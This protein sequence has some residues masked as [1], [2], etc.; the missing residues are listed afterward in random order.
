MKINTQGEILTSLEL[1]SRLPLTSAGPGFHTEKGGF[2]A[3]GSWTREPRDGNG[4]SKFNIKGR[5]GKK[6]QFCLKAGKSRVPATAQESQLNFCNTLIKGR[7]NKTS[8]KYSAL[9]GGENWM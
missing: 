6:S 2:G 5:Q 8:V 3:G 4:G 1:M 9:M 7:L